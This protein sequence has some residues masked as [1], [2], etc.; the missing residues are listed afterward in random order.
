MEREVIDQTATQKRHLHEVLRP[1]L[2]ISGI[3]FL[4]LVLSGDAL[5]SPP[6]CPPEP[7]PPT[8]FGYLKN[9]DIFVEG[10][11]LKLAGTNVYWLGLDFRYEHFV[12]PSAQRID[13]ILNAATEMGSNVIRTHGAI[14]L[15]CEICIEPTLGEFN[16]VGF[17]ALDYALYRGKQL[18]L[19][20][21]LPLTDNWDYNHGGRNTF[22]RWR[23]L[24]DPNDF[25]TNQQ[26]R[27]DYKD[28][29]TFILN[30]VNPYTGIRYKDDPT[31]LAWETGNEVNQNS[32]DSITDW[33][34]DIIAHIR[35][36]DKNHLL[37]DGQATNLYGNGRLNPDSLMNC[38]IDIVTEH[39]YPLTLD[40]TRENAAWAERFGKAYM[41]T[42]YG[43]VQVSLPWPNYPLTSESDFLNA[44]AHRNLGNIDGV[45]FWSL[46][47]ADDLFGLVR[48]FDGYTRYFPS[49]QTLL[50][51]DFAF[52]FLQRDKLPIRTPVTPEPFFLDTL[53][54]KGLVWYSSL[55]SQYYRIE[56]S[57]DN[58]TWSPLIEHVTDLD[59]PIHFSEYPTAFA[60]RYV[61]VIA[62]N[63]DNVSSPAS[64]AVQVP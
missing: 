51:R 40:W 12:F 64:I 7:L 61:R 28:Y 42:E 30:H 5:P 16:E 31:I 17:Q 32:A 14:S 10:E 2:K 57:L 33:T 56:G 36:L 22:V 3:A 38:D 46:F 54:G 20:F 6:I 23:G 50:F 58:E 34:T 49:N 45:L 24:S 35:S 1:L 39:A 48:H 37:I 4:L 19:Y 43:N 27:Q 47:G 29:I 55:G 59:L 8:G 21:I 9:S 52:E 63:P 41:V 13:N 44:V 25:F 60:P 53:K 18:G 11:Q 26:L 15:G 62:T